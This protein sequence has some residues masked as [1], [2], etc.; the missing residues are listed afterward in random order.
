MNNQSLK[1]GSSGPFRSLASPDWKKLWVVGHF[2]NVSFWLEF[3]VLTWLTLQITNSPFA[4]GLVGTIRFLPEPILG[5]ISGAQAD[6]FPKK[7]ILQ[8]AQLLNLLSVSIML[9]AAITNSINMPLIYMASLLTGCAWAIDFPVRRAY[10]RDLVPDHHVQNAMALD[11]SSLTLSLML[12]RWGAG[13]IL[14]IQGPL[15][16]YSVLLIMYSIGFLQLLRVIS[17]K[18]VATESR[19]SFVRTLIQGWQLVWG[20]PLLRGIFL[21]TFTVNF[22]VFPYFSF[23]P[24]FARDVFKVGEGW[25]GIMSGMDGFGALVGTSIIAVVTIKRRG[26]FHVFGAAWLSIGVFFYAFSP[27]FWSALPLLFISG[28]GMSLFA[29]MQNTLV[30]TNVNAEM[31]GRALGIMMLSLGVLSPGLVW[32]GAMVRVFGIRQAVGLNALLA[33]IIVILIGI[34]IKDLRRS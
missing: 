25:L 23:A 24:V 27:N 12:G 28:I 6:R 15:L 32:V 4:V 26:F 22:F 29:T 13:A 30:L 5:L 18:P 2:L 17:L 20:T 16:A 14:A 3:I 19:T 31:R 34:A 9:I 10:I 33:C 21:I 7:R 8:L 11:S 1:I